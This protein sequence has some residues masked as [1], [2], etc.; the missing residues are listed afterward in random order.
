M[1]WENLLAIY[2]D[3]VI[4]V[5]RD[6]QIL[7][8]SDYV[9]NGVS[10]A[11]VN[12]RVTLTYP[13]DPTI[14]PVR[15][16]IMAIVPGGQTLMVASRMLNVD[17]NPWAASGANGEVEAIITYSSDGG[18]FSSLEPLGS[19]K[20]ATIPVTAVNAGFSGCGLAAGNT[21]GGA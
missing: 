2:P 9:S 7:S 10:V 19:Q 12:G 6:G 16:A 20:N 1:A 3:A 17:G 18:T 11:V 15:W 5:N 21:G 14:T 13:D 4:A 8:P